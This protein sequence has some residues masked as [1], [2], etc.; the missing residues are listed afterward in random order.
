MTDKKKLTTNASCP[1]VDNQNVLTAG[2]RGA[3]LLQDVWF[4][5]CSSRQSVWVSILCYTRY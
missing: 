2:A 4:L 3:Q 1:F 5:S